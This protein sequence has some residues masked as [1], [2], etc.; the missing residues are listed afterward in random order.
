MFR[1]RVSTPWRCMVLCALLFR[2]ASHCLC[3]RIFL[4]VIPRT[5]LI[6]RCDIRDRIQPLMRDGS[7][8]GFLV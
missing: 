2:V 4:G 7:R 5:V 6:A 3:I 1:S 8:N